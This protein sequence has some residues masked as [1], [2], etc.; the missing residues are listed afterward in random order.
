MERDARGNLIPYEWAPGER[1][2]WEADLARDVAR[3]YA[4]CEYWERY[5]E[6]MPDDAKLSPKP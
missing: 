2:K 1:E 4:S 5:G 3:H 6:P